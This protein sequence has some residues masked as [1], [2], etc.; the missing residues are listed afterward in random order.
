MSTTSCSN[1]MKVLADATR[2]AVIER[3]LERPQR[4]H[5]LNASLRMDPTLLSHH[6]RV[7]RE[8]GLVTTKRDGKEILYRLASTVR[9]SAKS[10]TLDFGCCK[11]EFKNS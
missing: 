3:L 11:L 6:L 7:L 2:M 1:I 10:S 4:V 9:K 5:E 8:A